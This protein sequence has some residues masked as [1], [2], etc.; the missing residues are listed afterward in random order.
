MAALGNKACF[1]Y[2]SDDENGKTK[3]E[4]NENKNYK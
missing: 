3:H 1:D 2:G 4:N